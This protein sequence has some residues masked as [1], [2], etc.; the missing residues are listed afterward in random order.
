MTSDDFFKDNKEKFDTIFIDGL[1]IDEQVQK[2]IENSLNALNEGGTIV[3][4]D[5]K[6]LS[7][8]AQIFPRIQIAWNG[9]VWKAWLKTM[10]KHDDLSMYVV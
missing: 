4:H 5:C 10:I 7:E 8:E 6:P 9:D 3:M 1:H 2:D